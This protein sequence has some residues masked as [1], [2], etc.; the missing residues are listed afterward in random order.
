MLHTN[1]LCLIVL[2][3]LW[4]TRIHAAEYKRKNAE[5]T[6]AAC[7]AWYARHRRE[8]IRKIRLRQR[9]NGGQYLAAARKSKKKA[10]VTLARSYVVLCLVNHSDLKVADIPESLIDLKQAQLKLRRH[11]N[12]NETHDRS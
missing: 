11:L 9:L 7:R 5:L 2:G 1:F 6:R 10:S 8:R 4:R 3:R 12:G